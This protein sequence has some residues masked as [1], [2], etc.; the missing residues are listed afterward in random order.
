VTLGIALA[1]LGMFAPALSYLEEPAG[2]V[3]VAAVDGALAKALAL[4]P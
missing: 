1:R 3:D 2:P 4:S